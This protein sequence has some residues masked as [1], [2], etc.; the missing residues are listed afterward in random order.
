MKGKKGGRKMNR[1]GRRW[2]EGE[3]KGGERIKY[4]KTT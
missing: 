2:R 3:D 1:N 4:Q